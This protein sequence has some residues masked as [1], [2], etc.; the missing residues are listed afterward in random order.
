MKTK[1]HCISNIILKQLENLHNHRDIAP[2]ILNNEKSGENFELRVAPEQPEKKALVLYSSE[3]HDGTLVFTL[4]AI[5][6]VTSNIKLILDNY[7]SLG[8]VAMKK[9][10][11]EVK[12]GDLKTHEMVY[13]VL[14]GI[15]GEENSEQDMELFVQSNQEAIENAH[16]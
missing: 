13:A 8:L 15:P 9:V 7:K 2:M 11:A 5:S 12:E 1:V 3:L 10:E 14:Q 6:A 16:Q 4:N